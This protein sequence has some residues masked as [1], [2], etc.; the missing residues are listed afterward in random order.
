MLATIHLLFGAII[1]KSFSSLWVIIILAFASH[2]ILDIIP[3]HS[4]GEPKG[5]K[6]KGL[7]GCDKKDLIRKGVFPFFGV[8][9]MTILILT[10]K[11]NQL[12][13][14]LGASAGLLPDGLCYMAW[15]HDI[16]WANK[17]LPR[18][19][20]KLYNK[21]QNKKG[22][23]MQVLFFLIGLTLFLIK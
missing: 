11:E 22:I 13:L 17:V 15:K 19:G 23:M 9:L 8:I 21:L 7:R 3:H 6:E 16:G 20:T 18:P 10:S 5:W 14:I 4:F 2:Y 12:N 1:G